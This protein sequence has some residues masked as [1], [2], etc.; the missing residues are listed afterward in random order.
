MDDLGEKPTIFG[1]IHFVG[2]LLGDFFFG[3]LSRSLTCIAPEKVPKS[4]RK[5][6]SSD[7]RFSG[8]ML[9]FGGVSR[10]L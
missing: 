1:N 9:N 5:G 8:A 7:R 2:A 6:L 4:K 3:L 10:K